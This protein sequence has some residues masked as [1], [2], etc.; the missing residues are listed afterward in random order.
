VKSETGYYYMKK[1]A[2]PMKFIDIGMHIK[3]SKNTADRAVKGVE[4]MI[5]K[6]FKL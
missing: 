1:V 3:M 6:K 2:K 5:E 4:E